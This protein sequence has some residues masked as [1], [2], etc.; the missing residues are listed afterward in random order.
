MQ[1][2]S[3]D[4]GGFACFQRT[5][6]L[7]FRRGCQ[8]FLEFRGLFPSVQNSTRRHMAKRDLLDGVLH[9]MLLLVQETRGAVGDLAQLPGTH[10]F[11]GSFCDVDEGS[12]NSRVGGVFVGTKRQVAQSSRRCLCRELHPGRILVLSLLLGVCIH[13]VNAHIVPQWT[14]RYKREVI[15]TM[16]SEID[17]C[18]GVVFVGGDWSCVAGWYTRIRRH[19]KMRGSACSVTIRLLLWA[20]CFS[21]SPLF[22]GCRGRSGALQA[23]ADWTV[24]LPT[25][26]GRPLQGPLGGRFVSRKVSSDHRAVFFALRPRKHTGAHVF[27][28]VRARLR[29]RACGGGSSQMSASYLP[30][31]SPSDATERGGRW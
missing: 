22:G 1:R 27:V 25:F 31:S 17:R 28:N 9:A 8:S 11:Y 16:A 20:S 6:N 12:S 13:A 21:K 5:S 3:A 4:W 19:M 2:V 29:S 14:L 18:Q 30:I 26:T 24:F 10:I 7:D 23:S 15:Q